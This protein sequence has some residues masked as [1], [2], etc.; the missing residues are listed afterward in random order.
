MAEL[1]KAAMARGLAT[2][3]HWNVLIV[4]PPLVVS[5]DD[6]RQGLAILDEVLEV[7]DA[8]ARA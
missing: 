1:Q 5:A 2:M 8:A 3:I 7:T 4:V 6:A